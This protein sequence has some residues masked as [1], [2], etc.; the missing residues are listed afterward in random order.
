[1]LVGVGRRV[2]VSPLP[3]LSPCN[4]VD[5]VLGTGASFN[6]GLVLVAEASI[7]ASTRS[8][9]SCSTNCSELHPPTQ[10]YQ[11]RTQVGGFL[12]SSVR[13]LSPRAS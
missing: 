11:S 7:I 5:R 13:G 2:G 4:M 8:G 9:R 3:V 10:V 12:E 1:M 6:V